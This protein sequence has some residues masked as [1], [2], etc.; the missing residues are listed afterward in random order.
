MVNWS[1]FSL[2]TI[3]FPTHSIQ[4]IILEFLSHLS[5]G[6]SLLYPLD[7]ECSRSEY[8]INYKNLLSIFLMKRWCRSSLGFCIRLNNWSLGIWLYSAGVR[9]WVFCL[10]WFENSKKTATLSKYTWSPKNYYF[11]LFITHW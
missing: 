6:K 2:L 5:F 4:W 7:T 1:K 9:L 11:F 10:Q 3:F 8:M